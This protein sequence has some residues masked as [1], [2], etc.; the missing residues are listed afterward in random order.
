MT[1]LNQK[2]NKNTK[3]NK[4]EST[5]H[6]KI[7]KSTNKKQNVKDITDDDINDI[8]D[9]IYAK[10]KDKFVLTH[11]DM[12]L[13]WDV[14]ITNLAYCLM[15]KRKYS[16]KY[17]VYKWEKINLLSKFKEFKCII[18]KKNASSY[19]RKD[20]KNVFYCKVHV[21]SST[22]GYVK[23]AGKK[24]M[25]CMH[26]NRFNKECIHKSEFVL[27]TNK[28]KTYHCKKHLNKLI[29]V[30]KPIKKIEYKKVSPDYLQ[31]RL[32]NVLKNRPY[33]LTAKH[34]IIENQPGLLNVK[35]KAF[36]ATL[37]NYF[38]MRSTIDR[39]LFPKCNIDRV[40]YITATNKLKLSIKYKIS[41][42]KTYQLRKKLSIEHCKDLISGDEYCEKIFDRYTKKDD[43]SDAFLQ[44]VYYLSKH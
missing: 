29:P 36:S 22:L 6:V 13:S 34:V 21:K 24:E 30:F 17:K 23:V 16:E 41:K 2:K 25:K 18:C 35:M 12:I 43:I 38:Y 31:K 33:L 28:N 15:R 3:S 20:N 4:D 42:A 37:Y 8:Y 44:G 5:K 32:L 39:K 11:R 1:L 26:S 14:G 7:K 9:D 19:I 40:S 10:N 27:K